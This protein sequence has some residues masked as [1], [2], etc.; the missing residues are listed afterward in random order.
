MHRF[1]ISLA[2]ALVA[3]APASSVEAFCDQ[4]VP[5]L[6]RDDLGDDPTAM[7]Q[8]MDDHPLRRSYYRTTSLPISIL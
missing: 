1:L 6:S 5:A 2:L 3:C 7:Q 4:A 8:Q